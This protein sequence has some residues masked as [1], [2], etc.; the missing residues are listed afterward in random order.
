MEMDPGKIVTSMST[1]LRICV[2]SVGNAQFMGRIYSEYLN[3]QVSF[4]R[5][6]GMLQLCENYF[7]SISF[8]QKTHSPRSF[9]KSKAAKRNAKYLREW[10]TPMD[11]K[12]T[13]PTGDKATFV[14]HVMYRQN[15]SWQ[16]SIQWVE[17]NRTQF[18]RSTL[19]L[20]RL[21]DEAAGQDT[22]Y[23]SWNK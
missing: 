17:Q 23:A 15:T 3:K 12:I 4:D 10:S 20:I 13:F 1:Q 18:F 2:D 19:E 22:D 11:E 9:Q 5:F 14:V 6:E 21:M 8:P 16:G 7:D